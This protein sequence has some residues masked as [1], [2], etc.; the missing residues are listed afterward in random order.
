MDG[1]LAQ[2]LRIKADSE[3]SDH[4]HE[5][6]PEEAAVLSLLRGELDRP[7]TI[8]KEENRGRKRQRAK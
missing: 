2:T 5:L 3:I 8:T 6:E 1:K 7:L 4:L